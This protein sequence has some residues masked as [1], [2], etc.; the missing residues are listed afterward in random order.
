MKHSDLEYRMTVFKQNMLSYI[1]KLL[2]E[3]RQKK[4]QRQVYE[5][6]DIEKYDYRTK[7]LYIETQIKSAMEYY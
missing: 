2:T 1:E 5:L 3:R 4:R 7:K 6:R